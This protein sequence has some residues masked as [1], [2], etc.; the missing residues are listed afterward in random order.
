MDK[1]TLFGLILGLCAVLGGAILDGT[2][3]A[4]LLNLPAFLIVIG[5]TIGASSVGVS[6]ER[7][8][9]LPALFRRG[10]F[11]QR[12]E[13]AELV[14]LFVRLATTARREGLLSLEREAEQIQ[15]AYLRRG[16]QLLVD[17]SDDDVIRDIL[18]TDTKA[19]I[20]RHREGFTIFEV[21]GG[22]SPTMGIIGAVLGLIHVLSEV[23]DPTKLASGIAV[24]FV[25]TLYGVSSA[26]LIFFP[27][28]NKLR[29]RS[30]EEAQ[31]RELILNGVL[32]IQSGANPRIVRDKLEVFLA[33]KARSKA[34]ASAE[35][36]APAPV[37]SGSAS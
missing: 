29:F 7:M 25:A 32:A 1:A 4:G 14:D 28:A 26:N 8:L 34:A 18:T 16:I 21:M 35:A 31:T 10:L 11:P 22:Y 19:M 13:G 5:G 27:L 30:E 6:L 33:P 23:Q 12:Q 24:A 9:T 2:Q 20:E 15:D 37:A 17:G 3:I 36:A